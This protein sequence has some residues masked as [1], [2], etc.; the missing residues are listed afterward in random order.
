MEVLVAVIAQQ[1]R[2]PTRTQLLFAPFV[3]LEHFLL[4]VQYRALSARLGNSPFLE[5]RF[6]PK[7]AYQEIERRPL[8]DYA[9]PVRLATT[10]LQ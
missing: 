7:L 6:A 1:D 9:N 3:Q 2:L 10:L 8:P 4:R 5:H